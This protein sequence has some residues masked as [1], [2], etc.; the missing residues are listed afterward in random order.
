MAGD[1]VEE[2]RLA[3]PV[4]T[5]QTNGCGFGN[6]KI[7]LIEC[8][9]ATKA[10]DHTGRGEKWFRIA[11]RGGR[12]QDNL[13]LHANENL[14]IC[15]FDLMDGQAAVSMKLFSVLFEIEPPRVQWAG[16]DRA[17]NFGTFHRSLCVRA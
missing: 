5:E 14:A 4:L 3:R 12:C 8:L 13:L 2:S 11:M 7:D 1:D 6:E 17:L 16:Y 9:H 15:D 10:H